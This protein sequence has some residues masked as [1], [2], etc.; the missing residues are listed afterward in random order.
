MGDTLEGYMK[1]IQNTPQT[2]V[3]SN[4]KNVGHSIH[5]RALNTSGAKHA[6]V[7]GRATDTGSR[8]NVASH[9]GVPLPP[10]N[11]PVDRLD[12]PQPGGKTM[13]WPQG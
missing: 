6:H 1:T 13:G 3:P 10:D 12:S 9:G 8:Q 11:A 4:P 5:P 7:S 2:E